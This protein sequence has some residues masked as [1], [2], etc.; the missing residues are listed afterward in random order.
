MTVT[1]VA[2]FDNEPATGARPPFSA[3]RAVV[4][5]PHLRGVSQP[6]RARSLQVALLCV[7]VAVIVCTI[8][9]ASIAAA[10]P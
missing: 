4:P 10:S 8:V 7:V 2:L 3:P 9:I 1:W 6:A 5:Q